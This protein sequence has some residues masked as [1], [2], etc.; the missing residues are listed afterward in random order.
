MTFPT[1]LPKRNI[2]ILLSG[3]GTTALALSYAIED[4]PEL[5]DY[6]RIVFMGSNNTKKRPDLEM[7][8]RIVPHENEEQLLEQLKAADTDVV[9]LAGYM[10]ILTK[11]FLRH[12]YRGRVLNTHPS[13]LPAYKGIVDYE[14]MTHSA[15]MTG[16]T[17]HEVTKDVDS[18]TILDQISFRVPIDATA[19][20]LEAQ[21]K[22]V[23]Q[24][25]YPFVLKKALR[26]HYR[27]DPPC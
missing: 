15:R 17:V 1:S 22:I 8:H 5:S 9:L 19:Q 20:S 16:V 11:K 6:C 3:V 26:G 12:N 7:R 13:L 27:K 4:D 25:F 21:T 24:A 2:A 18:G 10:K 23:E 14:H